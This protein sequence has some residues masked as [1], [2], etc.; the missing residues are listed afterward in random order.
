MA[1]FSIPPLSMTPLSLCLFP[2]V[3]LNLKFKPMETDEPVPW[4]ASGSHAV[5][6]PS[7]TSA[8][9]QDQDQGWASVPGRG[10]T[11]EQPL[12]LC[13]YKQRGNG[14]GPLAFF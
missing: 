3:F 9:R 4:S 11:G 7:P 6:V 8:P 2:L 13:F 12:A 5:P 14:S 10:F 1:R